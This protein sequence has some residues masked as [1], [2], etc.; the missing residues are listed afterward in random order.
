[1]VESASSVPRQ[2]NLPTK[3]RQGGSNPSLDYAMAGALRYLLIK[4][5]LMIF[6]NSRQYF[7]IDMDLG[8]VLG[9][10]LI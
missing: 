6:I 4:E 7:Y 1:M 9:K 8:C 3:D 5:D 2:G 10:Q